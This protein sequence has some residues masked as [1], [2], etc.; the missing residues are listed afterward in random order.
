M[1]TMEKTEWGRASG[2]TAAHYR[3]STPGGMEVGITNYG[4]IL[5]QVRVPDRRGRCADVTLGFDQLEGYTSNPPYIGCIVGRVANR[6][7]GAR[8]ALDGREYVLAPNMAPN[9]LHGGVEGFNKK[10][11]DVVDET[12]GAEAAS[13]TMTYASAD[14]EEGYPGNLTAS[15]TYTLDA[16]NAL[17]VD[18]EAVTDAPTIVNLAHHAYWNLAGHDS[19][20][21]LDHELTLDARHYTPTDA[22]SLP[23]GEISA[24]AGTPFDF[25]RSKAIGADIGRLGGGSEG[26]GG[27]DI[28]LVLDGGAGELRRAARARD[29]KSGRVL[30]V[31]TTSPG[32]QFYTGNYLDGSVVGKGGAAYGRYA[33]FCL[34]TQHFPDA[35]NKEGRPGWPSVILRPGSTYEHTV[36][37]SF[38]AE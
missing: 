10:V 19:G 30:E 14:G 26:P 9:H 11:W 22:D 36:V 15:V 16:G 32:V 33:G 5:T 27:Y 18:M 4:A 3:M 38:S 12:R 13:L 23:T 1:I 24:V 6:I 7:G 34:E 29:P 21:I 25:T 37:F 2:K 28:N 35:I 17:K 20:D 8:F 31:G